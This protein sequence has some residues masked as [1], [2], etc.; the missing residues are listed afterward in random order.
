MGFCGQMHDH[1]WI[2]AFDH[3]LDRRGVADVGPGETIAGARRDAFQRGQGAGVGEL[4]QHV[5]MVIAVLHQPT[6]ERRP[7]KTRATRDDDSHSAFP[8]HQTS[9]RDKGTPS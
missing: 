4:V 7:D 8:A 9:I 1:I 2:D 5:D 6:H 3:G